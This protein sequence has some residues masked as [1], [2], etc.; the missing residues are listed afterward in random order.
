MVEIITCAEGLCRL[1]HDHVADLIREAVGC[2]I[3]VV[4]L[5]LVGQGQPGSRDGSS[6]FMCPVDGFSCLRCIAGLLVVAQ[7]VCGQKKLT[8]AGH[9]GQGLVRRH[10]NRYAS[11]Q[12]GMAAFHWFHSN[13]PSYIRRRDFR[14]LLVLSTCPLPSGWYVVVLD[15]SIISR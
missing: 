9:K 7:P 13:L 11:K 6:G 1:V 10:V 15:L 3:L 12:A 8:F 4:L 5:V 14:V 2:F